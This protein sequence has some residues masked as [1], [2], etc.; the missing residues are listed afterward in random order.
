[1]VIQSFNQGCASWERT[2]VK[3]C[4]IPECGLKLICCVMVLP[5]MIVWNGKE[6]FINSVP[7]SVNTTA[8]I[9]AACHNFSSDH[10]CK[11]TL[12]LNWCRHN[13]RK[14]CNLAKTLRWDHCKIS[15]QPKGTAPYHPPPSYVALTDTERP[16][17]YAAKNQ[18]K[19]VIFMDF[20]TLCWIFKL[21]GILRRKPAF[22]YEGI[23]P[24]LTGSINVSTNP[25]QRSPFVSTSVS[26]FRVDRMS[27]FLS[28]RLW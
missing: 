7:T 11:W 1:M 27:W 24:A 5:L 25:S 8:N 2:R 18:A 9:A 12:N 28:Q 14:H 16:I 15:R 26:A 13:L 21:I 20:C 10:G 22:F 3:C 23:D 6:N 4:C 17:G 19:L